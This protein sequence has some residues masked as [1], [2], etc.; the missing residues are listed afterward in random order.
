MREK[1]SAFVL[2]LGKNCW[3]VR[4]LV[5]VK[6]RQVPTG[7]E[8]IF[9]NEVETEEEENEDLEIQ[10]LRC[11]LK[12][13]SNSRQHFENCYSTIPV[14]GFNSCRYDLNLIKEYLLHHLLT[15]KTLFPK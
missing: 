10:R 7:A 11:E 4:Q 15:E 5:P 6:D 1:L 2:E 12:M 13:L 3:A 14:F 8:D 9:D